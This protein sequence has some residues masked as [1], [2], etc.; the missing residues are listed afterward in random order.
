M[1]ETNERIQE[2]ENE[3]LALKETSAAYSEEMR[4]GIES[5]EEEIRSNKAKLIET[6]DSSN[7]LK[8]EYQ[9]TESQIVSL[10]FSIENSKNTLKE[11]NKQR[12]E[13]ENLNDHWEH[14]IRTL[15]FY[16]NDLESQ[17]NHA[18]TY[19]LTLNSKIQ[20]TSIQCQ[21][22]FQKIQAECEEIKLVLK[23]SSRSPSPLPRPPIS[24]RSQ[25]QLAKLTSI[26]ITSKPIF[27][28][29]YKVIII[30]PDTLYLSENA[31]VVKEKSLKK[32]FE[33][34]RVV[35]R[36]LFVEEV[37][38][39]AD[40]SL[41]GRNTCL[42]LCSG[43]ARQ[44]L[45]ST[46]I[47][48]FSV[49]FNGRHCE[50]NCVEVVKD[51]A[52]NLF[53][54]EW[55][56]VN[57]GVESE[58]FVKEGFRRMSK[59][60]SHFLITFKFG[61][62]ILQVLDLGEV[63]DVQTLSESL[64]LNASLFYLEELMMNLS[65]GKPKFDKTNLTKKLQMSLCDN[66]FLMFLMNFDDIADIAVLGLAS[67]LQSMFSRN[68]TEH[69]Q[70]HRSLALLEKERLANFDILRIIEKAQKDMALLRK[71]QKE[72]DKIIDGLQKTLKGVKS[73]KTIALTPT[74]SPVNKKFSRIPIPK[75]G[76]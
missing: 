53:P 8:F 31:V 15:E 3:I 6:Q 9:K 35:K 64:S 32:I 48:K 56:A 12:A 14:S 21:Q 37:N 19:V 68:K 67:R 22:S 4:Q 54:F 24:P 7:A 38:E 59:G 10:Q 29:S 13:L 76:K 47:H 39:L 72:K 60:R 41:L 75:W 49:V 61:D 11:F 73:E 52:I 63:N 42:V 17:L 57:V 66:F 62:C 18:Q 30:S 1:E 46:V 50:L 26:N 44:E 58:N 28:E 71:A 27:E 5:V 74:L 20:D 23:N 25:M 36:S 69:E 43:K 45:V 40:Y 34:N 65:K 70:V 33:F 51:Q 2:L 16:N 55:R